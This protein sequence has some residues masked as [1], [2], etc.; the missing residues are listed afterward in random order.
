M[1]AQPVVQTQY[2][3]I[4]GVAA[5]R[6]A[7]FLGVRYAAS[8]AGRRFQKAAPPEPWTDVAD[9]SHYGPISPQHPRLRAMAPFGPAGPAPE[10]E[11]M[12][13]VNVWAPADLSGA[14]A[15]LV[16]AHGGAWFI[17]SSAMAP[18]TMEGSQLAKN[19]DLV[20]VSFNHRLG[21]LGFLDLASVTD[22]PEFADAGNLGAL[23][24]IEVLRW[25]R[26]NIASFG[27]DPNNV[28]IAGCSGGGQKVD[29]LMG[30][31]AARGLFHKAI[32]QSRDEWCGLDP[33]V[34]KLSALK[35]L[36]AL[37]ITPDRVSDILSVPLDRLMAAAEASGALF[38]PVIDGSVLP[39][40]PFGPVAVSWNKDVPLLI[41]CTSDEQ[42][43]LLGMSGKNLFG[44]SW[45]ALE[46]MLVPDRPDTNTADVIAAFREIDPS[47]SASDLLFR[48]TTWSRIRWG[49]RAQAET[50]IRSGGAPVFHYELVWAP[51]TRGGLLKAFHG[52]DVPLMFDNVQNAAESHG[53]DETGKRLAREMSGAW[54]AFAKTGSPNGA[55]LPR[56]E[57]FDIAERRTL[58][59]GDTTRLV[60]DYAGDEQRIMERFGSVASNVPTYGSPPDPNW[61]LFVY[62]GPNA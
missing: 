58:V 12:M 18:T 48:I 36:A 6:V 51:P 30:M 60:S 3:A 5:G 26:E 57:P 23:D 2:G 45:E 40:H 25:V 44:L 42:T 33:A 24:M 20:V 4:R 15:V 47:A 28:T 55:G 35:V 31:P 49:S 41:G 13:T 14:K 38:G 37:D 10:S 52:M 43:V 53:D 17:G 27:G 50:K 16:W 39:G 8:T 62:T 61:R 54:A 29:T 32:V 59:Y 19:H 22:A 34:A 9:A 21:V 11:D 1:V 7:T 46:A 56:W